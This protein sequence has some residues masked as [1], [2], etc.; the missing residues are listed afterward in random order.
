MNDEPEFMDGVMILTGIM[1]AALVAAW[2]AVEVIVWL[3]SL[4]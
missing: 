1:L 3:G 4:R 2:A